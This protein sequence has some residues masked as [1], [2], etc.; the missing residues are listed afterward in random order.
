[1]R[2]AI[3]IATFALGV[4]AAPLPVEQARDAAVLERGVRNPTDGTTYYAR[5]A[6]PEALDDDVSSNERREALLTFPRAGTQRC[7]PEPNSTRAGQRRDAD[8]EPNSTRAGQ[9]R[10]PEPNSIRASQRRDPEPV[11]NSTRASQRREAEAEA[12][13]NSTRAGQRR[14]PEPNSTRAGQRRDAE[15]NST[16]AG[17]RRSTTDE[18][19]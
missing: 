15:P 14:D 9:R 12:E 13:P 18:E 7:D 17:Q 10:E 11:P 3:F 6:A 4:F 5:E 1:M 8:P 2:S 19:Y 16:R